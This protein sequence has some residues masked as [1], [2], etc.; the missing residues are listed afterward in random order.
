MYGENSK[1]LCSA[2]TLRKNGITQAWDVEELAEVGRKVTACP[3]YASVS[4]DSDFLSDV[5]VKYPVISVDSG[6]YFLS[7]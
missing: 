5:F 3:Y 4:K 2:S 6:V 7:T 1:A